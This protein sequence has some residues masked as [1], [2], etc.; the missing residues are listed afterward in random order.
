VEAAAPPPGPP[1]A[2]TPRLILIAALVLASSCP[3]D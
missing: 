1:L 3:A 2:G